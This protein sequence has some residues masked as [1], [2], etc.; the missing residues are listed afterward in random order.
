MNSFMSLNNAIICVSVLSCVSVA[1]LI[2]IIVVIVQL[3]KIIKR[4]N[5][6]RPNYYPFETARII[7]N[8]SQYIF[9][10]LCVDD[11]INSILTH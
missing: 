8:E 2:F 5:D 1:C 7:D 9:F 11:S 10:F 4:K 6:F 3:V